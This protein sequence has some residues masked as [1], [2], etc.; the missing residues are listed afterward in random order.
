MFQK[1]IIIF[2]RLS[3]GGSENCFEFLKKNTSSDLFGK[4]VRETKLAT[5]SAQFLVRKKNFLLDHFQ[6]FLSFFP[7]SRGQN[8][9]LKDISH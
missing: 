9:Q 7:Q 3:C 1:K 8:D 6:L 2:S 5:F 4:K